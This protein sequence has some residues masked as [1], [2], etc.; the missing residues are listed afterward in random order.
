MPAT[1]LDKLSEARECEET[2]HLFR[3]TSL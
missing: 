2:A 1:G 3:Y